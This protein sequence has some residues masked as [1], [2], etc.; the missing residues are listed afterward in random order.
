MSETSKIFQSVQNGKLRFEEGNNRIILN[1]GSKDRLLIGEDAS[2]SMAVNLSQVGQD[3]KTAATQELIFSSSNNLFKIINSGTINLSHP[4]NSLVRTTSTP[5]GLNYRPTVL[6]WFSSDATMNI[7]EQTPAFEIL[8][9]SGAVLYHARIQVNSTNIVF[10]LDTPSG[11]GS[12]PYYTGSYTTTFK[13][14][15]LA[16]SAQ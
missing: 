10:A 15:V 14:Y 11:P 5:H 9:A 16:E 6:G 7:L 2:G 12:N 8:P 13:Y 1:D 3:V 4:V